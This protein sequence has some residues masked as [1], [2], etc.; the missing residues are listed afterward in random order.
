MTDRIPATFTGFRHSGYYSQNPNSFV[1][2]WIGRIL[3]KVAGFRTDRFLAEMAR[4]RRWI[5]AT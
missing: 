3:A 1:E 4:F 5:P 2:I